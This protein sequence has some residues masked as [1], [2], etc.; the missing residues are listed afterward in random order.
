MRE[1]TRIFQWLRKV[2]RGRSSESWSGQSAHLGRACVY[3]Q[4]MG[5][6]NSSP[7]AALSAQCAWAA[8]SESLCVC[9][10][11]HRESTGDLFIYARLSDLANDAYILL[12]GKLGTDAGE[13]RSNSTERFAHFT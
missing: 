1:K 10:P 13:T 4:V 5:T 8:V 11:K 7:R 3:V 6:L 2:A 12:R 9:G